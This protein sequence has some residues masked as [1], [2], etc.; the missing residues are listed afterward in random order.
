[1]A[2]VGEEENVVSGRWESK[3]WVGAWHPE[4]SAKLENNLG[5]LD[6]PIQGAIVNCCL[7]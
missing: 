5:L 6:N 2:L 3:D 4:A 1:M 7:H